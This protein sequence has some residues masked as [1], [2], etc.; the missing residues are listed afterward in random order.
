MELWK[1]GPRPKAVH[2]EAYM[3]VDELV[4]FPICV[5]KPEYLKVC[6]F[7]WIVVILDRKSVV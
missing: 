7:V 4:A 5:F 3:E 1:V 2:F 6:I